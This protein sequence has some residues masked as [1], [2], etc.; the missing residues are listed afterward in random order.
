M[1]GVAHVFTFESHV[2]L[3]CKLAK[4]P[5]EVSNMIRVWLGF[6]TMAV[7]LDLLEG[8]YDDEPQPSTE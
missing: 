3:F 5:E 1:S 4:F 7:L 6:D 8:Q 2:T